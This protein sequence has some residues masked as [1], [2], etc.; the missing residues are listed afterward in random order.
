TDGPGLLRFVRGLVVD[1]KSEARLKK[2]VKQLGDDDFDMR[3]EA[4]RQLVAAGAPA[5]PFL[6][7]ALKD[8][9]QEVV[10]R[11][12]KCLQQIDQGLTAVVTSSAVRV[13]ALRK[14]EGA[15]EVLLN[16]LA[17]AD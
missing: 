6:Q 2:L 3:E 11:A 5:R 17:A 9:D 15:A 8:G 7:E 14:P 13:L 10:G 12:R 16:Y 4:T 1:E